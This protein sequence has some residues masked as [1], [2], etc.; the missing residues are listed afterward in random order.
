MTLGSEIQVARPLFGTAESFISLFP[1]RYRGS[2]PS[3]CGQRSFHPPVFGTQCPKFDLRWMKQL[4]LLTVQTSR[5]CLSLR[6]GS[7]PCR[8]MRSAAMTMAPL[9]AE[10]M[11]CGG[12]GNQGTKLWFNYERVSPRTRR[13][14][15]AHFLLGVRRIYR[16]ASSVLERESCIWERKFSLPM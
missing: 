16:L 6:V 14:G 12:I 15:V 3:A 9:N 4:N 2:P 8:A 13:T 11:T 10:A 1:A 7:K 5:G